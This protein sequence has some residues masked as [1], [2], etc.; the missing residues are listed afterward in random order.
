[1]S[2]NE[3]LYI[4]LAGAYPDGTSEVPVYGDRCLS[5]NGG[6]VTCTHCV[7]HPHMDYCKPIKEQPQCKCIREEEV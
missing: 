6:P 4:C 1:M 3:K 7:P 2:K 5:V